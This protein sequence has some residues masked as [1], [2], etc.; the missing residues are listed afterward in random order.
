[1][2][3]P[4]TIQSH[5]ANTTSKAAAAATAAMQT[6]QP[7]AATG[8][9]VLQTYQPS[10]ARGGG[11]VAPPLSAAGV[12][13]AAGAPAAASS[14][15]QAY[16][17]LA[18]ASSVGNA[19]YY[20]SSVE[21]GAVG[22]GGGGEGGEGGERREGGEGG[23]RGERGE[24][25][26]VIDLPPPEVCTAAIL[27]GNDPVIAWTTFDPALTV[28]SADYVRA[29]M[30]A[31]GPLPCLPGC[32]SPGLRAHAKMVEHALKN[33]YWI[34]TQREL[35]IVTMGHH[36]KSG[37]RAISIPLANI[38]DCGIDTGG[39]RSWGAAH[40][41]YDTLPSICIDTASGLGKASRKAVGVGLLNHDSF[42]RKILDQRLV[43]KGTR[44]SSSSSSS[45]SSYALAA[46][47]TTTMTT[48]ITT[49]AVVPMQRGGGTRTGTSCISVTDRMKQAK[50][51]Y[52]QCLISLGE[53]EKKRQ[54]ILAG[55]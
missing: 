3:P 50:E 4:Q 13:A 11:R 5:R 6:Y 22:G 12:V 16:Y 18:A 33:Q 28:R 39:K 27:R 23:E 8:V 55:V 45:S 21:G 14:S 20:N 17:S 31:F 19:K 2:L 25:G 51:L 41:Q 26:G 49:A 42:L 30:I 40:Y 34:L 52:D 10:S 46:T 24:G 7:S 48:A 38:T 54:D 29:M 43:V 35:K 1:V 15:Q 47:A 32:V 53:Y 36:A 9:V 37:H 44:T